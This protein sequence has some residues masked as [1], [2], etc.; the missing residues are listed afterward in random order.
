MR[1]SH[2]SP[3]LSSHKNPR[4]LT[5]ARNLRPAQV[6][7]HSSIGGAD[8]REPCPIKNEREWRH[9]MRDLEARSSVVSELKSGQSWAAPRRFVGYYFLVIET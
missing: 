5:V 7:N 1:S 6:V 3:S 2:E 4:G 8:G 9:P